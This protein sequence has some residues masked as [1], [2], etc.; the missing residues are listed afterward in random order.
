MTQECASDTEGFCDSIV[1]LINCLSLLFCDSGK[2]G[3]FQLFYKQEAGD[4]EGPW[5]CAGLVGGGCMALLGF[6]S[7][8]M[9]LTTANLE[10]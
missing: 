5:Y 1:L 9:L 6:I 7:V 3:K 2:P 4:M 8:K 10:Q